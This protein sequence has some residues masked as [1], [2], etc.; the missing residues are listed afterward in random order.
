MAKQKEFRCSDESVNSYGFRVLTSGID[1]SQFE[2]NP[3]MLYDHRNWDMPP[4]RWCNLRKEGT[5]LI[6]TPEFDDKDEKARDLK[7][8]VDGGYINMTS[9]GIVPIEWS[10]DPKL[11]LPGQTGP[12]L[13]KC[14]LKE[15][16]LTPFGS[17]LNALRLY[18][19]N[20]DTINLNNYTQ[21]KIENKMNDLK[22][23]AGALDLHDDATGT[24]VVKTALELKDKA[25]KQV[26]KITKLEAEVKTLSEKINNAEKE[27]LL[28]AAVADKRITEKEKTAF[29]KLP[30]ED[31][32][33]VLADRKPAV[34]LKSFTQGDGDGEVAELVKLSWSELDKQGKLATLKEK[35]FETFKTKFKKQFGKEYKQ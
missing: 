10:E 6:A 2:R 34:D 17:N 28:G 16:S 9:I 21:I 24:E 18:D 30:V 8:K 11:M 25:A 26:E 33:T 20:G 1:T 5:Q 32:K 19:D 13:V 23:I 12:T 22:T 3:V 4:G 35:D 27:T 31:I 14:R 7:S 29:L 15:I